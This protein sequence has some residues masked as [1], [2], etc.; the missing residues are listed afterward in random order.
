M[1]IAKTLLVSDQIIRGNNA[2]FKYIRY[3]FQFLFEYFLHA[4]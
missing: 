2:N 3:E 1:Q 4:K